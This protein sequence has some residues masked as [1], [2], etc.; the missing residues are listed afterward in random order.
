[1]LNDR[2]EGSYFDRSEPAIGVDHPDSQDRAGRVGSSARIRSG[3]APPTSS[4]TA[5][6]GVSLSLSMARRSLWPP[7]QDLRS[8][9]TSCTPRSSALKGLYAWKPQLT[10]RKVRF[11]FSYDRSLSARRP[12]NFLLREYTWRRIAEL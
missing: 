10:A 9:W 11:G 12:V 6:Q 8:L 7:G 2:Y 3:V 5:F 4:F 1:M